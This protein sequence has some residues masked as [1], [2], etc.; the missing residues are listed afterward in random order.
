MT[1]LV[2]EVDM[3]SV[4]ALAQRRRL[5]MDAWRKL[6]PLLRTDELEAHVDL[7]RTATRGRQ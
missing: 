7:A 1:D 4:R 6:E 5:A 3:D 2:S